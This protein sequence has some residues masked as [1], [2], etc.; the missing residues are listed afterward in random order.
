MASV[1]LSRRVEKVV[2][3]P[4]LAALDALQ[5]RE[6][7]ERYSIRAI[8]ENGG[9]F[10]SHVRLSIRK[11]GPTPPPHIPCL[12]RGTCNPNGS[13]TEAAGVSPKGVRRR[14]DPDPHVLRSGV[15]DTDD[16]STSPA[17]AGGHRVRPR[18]HVAPRDLAARL[19]HVFGDRWH[20][21]PSTRSQFEYTPLRDSR[22]PHVRGRIPV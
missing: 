22:A 9:A 16:L 10:P 21:V 7:Y 5:R 14:T 18:G 13:T 1:E 15:P 17:L 8:R 19:A 3:Y 4:P 11:C 2:G 12:E 6:L 20:A